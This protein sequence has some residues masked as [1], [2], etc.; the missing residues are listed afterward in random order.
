MKK[1]FFTPIE[2]PEA[3]VEKVTADPSVPG[4]PTPEQFGP[5]LDRIAIEMD[6]ITEGRSE[7]TP[8]GIVLTT[9]S[10]I[11]NVFN[12]FKLEPTK[13]NMLE[14]LDMAENDINLR[15]RREFKKWLNLL[16]KEEE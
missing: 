5:I 15:A 13:K 16:L 6:K 9:G 3:P 1:S 14:F 7:L 12:R 11:M 4:W 8:Y 2:L 10:G